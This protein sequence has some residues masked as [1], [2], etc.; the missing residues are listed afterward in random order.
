MLGMADNRIQAASFSLGTR[1]SA[2]ILGI[3][4]AP[5]LDCGVHAYDIPLEGP[6]ALRGRGV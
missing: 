5:A 2:D 6:L 4:A 3:S 1:Q